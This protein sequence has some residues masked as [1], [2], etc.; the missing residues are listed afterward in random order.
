MYLLRGFPGNSV[1]KNPPEIW[2]TQETWVQSLDL[3][4][5]LEEGVATH[6]SVLAKKSPWTEEPGWLQYIGSQ[7]VRHGCSDWVCLYACV[8]CHFKLYSDCFYSSSLFLFSLVLSPY[9]LTIFCVMFGSLSLF[10]WVFIM[11]YYQLLVFRYH[12]VHR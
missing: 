3:E 6:S 7:R 5:T 4:D 11:L 10:F 12:E 1:V 9:Y 8:Y 2:E